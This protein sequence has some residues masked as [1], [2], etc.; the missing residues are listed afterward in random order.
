MN[1]QKYA[2]TIHFQINSQKTAIA[3]ETNT[4]KVSVATRLVNV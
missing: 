2:S 3:P 4:R 1:L